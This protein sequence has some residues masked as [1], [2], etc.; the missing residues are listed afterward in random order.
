MFRLRRP[1]ATHTLSQRAWPTFPA[2]PRGLYI[3][4]LENEEDGA[5][6]TL[7]CITVDVRSRMSI[8]EMIAKITRWERQR[9]CV[10]CKARCRLQ[11]HTYGKV[12]SGLPY[13]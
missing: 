13:D 10:E 4:R 1:R 7:L 9:L 8:I 6:T 2:C 3:Q 11:L 5:N 12:V